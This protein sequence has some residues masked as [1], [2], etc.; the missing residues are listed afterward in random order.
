MQPVARRRA[1][2]E[3]VPRLWRSPALQSHHRYLAN[4]QDMCRPTSSVTYQLFVNFL[5]P[6]T[7]YVII[8]FILKI[9]M[10]FTLIGVFF[11]FF[12]QKKLLFPDFIAG[13]PLQCIFLH[14]PLISVDSDTSD[15][16]WT[17]V[18][19][20]RRF[21]DTEAQLLVQLC[22]FRRPYDPG[23]PYVDLR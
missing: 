10:F 23:G 20:S 22:I 9:T 8:I 21:S 16:C 11:E 14:F 7:P 2:L 3:M 6:I 15:C 19:H 13:R 17:V 4:S 1:D 12:D 18:I 5:R